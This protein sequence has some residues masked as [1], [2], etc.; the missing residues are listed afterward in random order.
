MTDFTDAEHPESITDANYLV[1][2]SS[3]LV[4]VPRQSDPTHHHTQDFL[5]RAKKVSTNPQPDKVAFGGKTVLITG[6]GAGLGRAYALMYAKLGA[7]VVVNDMSQEN[8]DG[9]VAEIKKS[10]S[11]SFPTP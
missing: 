6:A 3:P 5:E 8:A 2:P 4:Q 1:R 7:N 10:R 11:F 9:V